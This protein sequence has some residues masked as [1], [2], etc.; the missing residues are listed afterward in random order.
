M[1]GNLPIYDLRRASSYYSRDINRVKTISIH[2]WA[3]LSVPESATV[4]QEVAAIETIRR[5]HAQSQGWPDYAYHFTAFQS[6]RA[7]YTGDI[8][9]IRYV[10]GNKNPETI[11]IAL[12]GDFTN[13]PPSNK[14]LLTVRGLVGEIQYAFGP[15][16]PLTV[17]PHKYYGGTACPGNTWDQWADV[18]CVGL[19]NT[20]DGEPGQSTLQQEADI[21]ESAAKA[22][23]IDP[24]VLL[25]LSMGEA[26]PEEGHLYNPG[27]RRPVD[28]ANDEKQWPDVSSGPLHQTVRWSQEYIDD[29]GRGYSLY[30]GDDYVQAVLDT[31]ENAEYA[32]KVGAEK[33]AG[34]LKTANGNA[35]DALCL[36]NKPARDPAANP[37][38]KRYELKLAEAAQVWESLGR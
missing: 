30:P 23:G 1:I 4:D 22:A 18:V 6:G 37:H 38:R 8:A 19:G 32:F 24:V 11:A 2:H 34:H 36:Y 14:H 25:G 9:S 28:P 27:K 33:L 29:F 12:P 20:E 17:V 13:E 31:Y 35:L 21:L 10:V 16:H 7:Y 5:Q 26:D 15:G 3:G